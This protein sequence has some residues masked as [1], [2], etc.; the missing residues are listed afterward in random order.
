MEA[1]NKGQSVQALGEMIN[2]QKRDLDN[3]LD[4][5]LLKTV[6]D[7]K[8]SADGRVSSPRPPHSEQ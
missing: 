7:V 4:K 8:V 1:I 3:N 2:G 6:T 5:A